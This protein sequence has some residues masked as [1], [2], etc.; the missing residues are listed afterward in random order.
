VK[1]LETWPSFRV[2]FRSLPFFG[3]GDF[4]Y[5]PKLTPNDR[6]EQVSYSGRESME[7]VRLLPPTCTR[8]EPNNRTFAIRDK[9]PE[10]GESSGRGP[11][12][13][14][15]H[16]ANGLQPRL[17]VAEIVSRLLEKAPEAS[18]LELK[19]PHAVPDTKD[20][21]L[22]PRAPVARCFHL[23]KG[24]WTVKKRLV[25]IMACL[26]AADD[27][28]MLPKI[29]SYVECSSRSSLVSH[30]SDRQG[31]RFPVPVASNP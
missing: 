3:F 6:Y 11:A 4:S 29:L 14:A 21:V 18:Y 16:N 25:E 9:G 8:P 22:R 23:Q 10:D 15:D 7:P 1:T 24:A 5:P 2:I 12:L 27:K 30:S 31:C 20:S 26:G 19:E 17:S 28:L 13:G